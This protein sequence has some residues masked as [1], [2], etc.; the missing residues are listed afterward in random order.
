FYRT[1]AGMIVVFHVLTAMSLASFS[2]FGGAF[3]RKA[4]LS[5]VTMV[6]L[7]LVLGI[8]GQYGVPFIPIVMDVLIMF[9]PPINYVA[10]TTYVA[11]CERLN[12]GA[13]FSAALTD[14]PMTEAGDRFFI[15]CLVHIILFS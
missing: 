4:Q 2:I 5:G 1:S 14:A 3:F 7:S 10:F 15:A 6:V 13:D 9:F 8:I 12:H 11:W